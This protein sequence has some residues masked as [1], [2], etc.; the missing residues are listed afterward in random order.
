MLY[1]NAYV[2]QGKE[3]FI[4]GGLRVTD[5]RIAQV[6]RGEAGA[7]RPD[8]GPDHARAGG[9]QSAEYKAPAD[10][11]PEEE[12]DLQGMYVIPGLVDIHSHGNSGCDFSDGD[13][14][15]LKVMGR[16][17][18][19][20][21]ITSFLPTSMTLPYDRLET[22]FL[23][24]KR[25][26]EEWDGISS[27]LAG[28]HMEGPF[29]SKKKKGAQNSAYLRLPDA[30][31]VMQLQKACG[32]L[33]RIVDVA[34]ELPGAEAFIREMAAHCR[35]SVA[36]TDASYEE[37]ARAFDAGAL[38]VTHLFNAM[39]SLHHRKPGVIGAA[40]ERENVTAELIC[41]G[42]HVHPSVIRLAFKLFA[43]RICMV[44]DSLRC[45]GMPD[46]E[47]DLGGQTVY[48][49]NGEARLADGTLAGDVSDLYSDMV[50]AIRFGIPAEQAVM[51][52]TI[53][54]AEAIGA[55]HEIGSLEE[56]KLADFVVC[57]RNWKIGQ[58]VIG[59][60]RVL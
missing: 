58:V 51:A 2:F 34:P 21:G 42:L 53:T 37:A 48:L 49:R 59:G 16:F 5:G 11:W 47:Y 41:D 52:A 45:C 1:T 30:D 25:Y 13:P 35:V 20:H 27:R 38:H 7:D 40:A 12:T 56:G 43:D 8:H 18:A 4:K 24:A 6:I 9:R 17:D 31:A 55:D 36:H 44:S 26:R 57:D 28:I 3:G 10:E 19:Q 23:T 46:G 39:P 29:F 50:N 14:E 32:G 33:I 22:A 54:P 15:G 60:K